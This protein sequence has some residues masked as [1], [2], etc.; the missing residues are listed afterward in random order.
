MFRIDKRRERR[1]M[2]RW[3]KNCP[4]TDAECPVC[5]AWYV[6]YTFNKVT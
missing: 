2:R 4:D 5:R 1:V 3:G 6:F